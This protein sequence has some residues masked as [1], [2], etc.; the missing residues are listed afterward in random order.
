MTTVDSTNSVPLDEWV[1]HLIALIADPPPDVDLAELTGMLGQA[2]LEWYEAEPDEGLLTVAI[3][4]LDRAIDGAAH[5]DQT[6]LWHAGLGVAHAERARLGARSTDHD[7]AIG[8]L[9]AAY[10]G[11]P[12]DDPERDLVAVDLLEAT[13]DRF[14][15]RCLDDGR[16]PQAAAADADEVVAAIEAIRVSA[17]A[18]DLAAYVQMVRGMA[19][20]AR[21]DCGGEREQDLEHGIDVLSA[22][23]AQLPPDLTPGYATASADLAAA[24]LDMAGLREDPRSVELAA[25]V[26]DRGIDACGP[27]QPGWL[28]L[29]RCRATACEVLWD[30]GE[31]S[32][33]LDKAIGSWRT[34]AEDDADPTV[35]VTLA[36]LLRSGAEHA[37]DPSGLAEAVTLLEQALPSIGHQAPG[38]RQL[39][40]TH[41]LN[42]QLARSQASRDAAAR[43]VEHALAAAGTDDDVLAAHTTRLVLATEV[44]EYDAAQEA[45]AAQTSLD[46]LV[47]ALDEADQVLDNRGSATTRARVHLAT[48]LV[49]ADFARFSEAEDALDLPR[50][51][52]LITLGRALGADA[53]PRLAGFLD[54]A[55]GIVEQA[56]N[57]SSATGD[58]NTAVEALLRAGR[59]ES[60]SKVSGDRIPALLSFALQTRAS[61]LGDLRGSRAAGNLTTDGVVDGRP[62]DPF[63]AEWRVWA[64]AMVAFQ[65]ARQGD[66]VGLRRAIAHA[67]AL[68][69]RLGSS[70]ENDTS[71][72]LAMRVLDDMVTVGTGRGEVRPRSP[73]PLPAR[74]L[75]HRE[76]GVTV[77]VGATQVAAALRRGDLPL[78]RRWADHL[79]ALAH[80]LE[81]GHTA[82]FVSLAVAA[83]AELG[84]ASRLGDRAAAGRAVSHF[85]A[86]TAESGGPANALWT[87]LTRDHAEALRR[88]GDPDRARTRRLGL[89]ALHG[90]ARRVLLQA[91]TDHAM[92][93]ARVAAADA[94]TVVR[95]CLQDR[96][97]DDLVTAL[98]AGRGLVLHAAT[99]SR[100]IADSLREAGH[101]DLAEEW[102]QTA[103]LGRD[104]ATG[105]PLG[106]LFAAGEVPDDLRSRVLRALE[107]A[108]TS[109][110]GPL[111]Q[112]PVAEIRAALAELDLDALVY[113]VP[114]ARPVPGFAAIV[115]ATGTIEVIELPD[116][117]VGD[118]SP[119][120]KLL[121]AALGPAVTGRGADTR[122]SRPRD[123]G[124]VGAPM[125]PSVG[126]RMDDLCRW[127]WRAAMAR[128]VAETR[129][130]R[131]S[132]P[133]RLV[134]IPMGALG[135][136]P[137]HAAYQN[138]PTGRRYA[139]HDLVLSYSPSARMLCT[140][141]ARPPRAI[142]STLVVGDPL[143]DLPFAGVE[144]RAIHKRFHQEGQ[145]LGGPEEGPDRIAHPDSVLEWIRAVGGRGASLLHLACHGRVDTVRPADSYLVLAGGQLPARHLLE[146]SRLAA[147]DLGHVFLAACTTNLVGADYDEAFSLATAFLAAG[148]H[149]VFGSLWSVP[150]VGTSL[151]MYLVHH[152]LYEEGHKPADALHRAQLWMLDPARQPPDGMP[153]ELAAQC[154]R[155]DNAAPLNWAAFTHLGR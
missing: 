146:V 78:L 69:R 82:R 56:A 74:Q 98:D 128:L 59:D 102:R 139:V 57:A 87:D 13:W 125:P 11:W 92:D 21:Y 67:G 93:I 133:P 103:G 14:L 26:A 70:F 2:Y 120:Q 88:S 71:Y 136:V 18:T 10:Q 140:A 68:A 101:P 75:T 109:A 42:W 47:A 89:A 142:R 113:L 61:Q 64:A 126:A 145:Y 151:L 112:V 27:G 99:A 20:L 143:G 115:P 16:P 58:S 49:Y 122:K 48:V 107:N 137:W 96:A 90:H 147:L 1:A 77:L 148:A 41:R 40:E 105:D 110:Q 55:E 63:A 153:A 73:V 23:L 134:L 144:A 8:H 46:H 97:D 119:L 149:T 121:Q 84:A 54:M 135:L 60:F 19:L 25:T 4:H 76:L 95:W 129:S 131:Q 152:F 86:A 155:P 3:A 36:E 7:Q 138:T 66:V 24:H 65:R 9:T 29:H 45:A 52:H 116:L 81:P 85:E 15:G 132:A 72:R 108:G 5:H 104:Q 91:G 22:A 80:R 127:A 31:D 62:Q 94:T 51:R 141:A 43:A 79:A 44:L 33:D 32:G 83:Q 37:S 53:P 38:W 123:A 111:A 118:G 124:P 114:A 12:A 154:D 106:A 100:T 17:T 117:V 35:A 130:T 6:V 50:L 34:V 150:D 30:L 28:S 39:A